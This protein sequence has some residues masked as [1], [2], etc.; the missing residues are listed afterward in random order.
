[1][2]LSDFVG[3][4]IVKEELEQAFL[5]DM[6]PH[7]L[8]IEGEKGTGKRTLAEIIAQYCVCRSEGQKPC[9]F[10][11]GC[12]KALSHSHPDIMVLDGSTPSN[13]NVEAIR[14]LRTSAFIIPNEAPRKVYI[15]A[16][17]D[18][19]N[20]TAQNA[21]LKILEEPPKSV[22]FIL[23][24]ITASSL[25]LTVRSRSRILSLLTPDLQ[26]AENAVLKS[27]PALNPND[28][29][30]AAHLTDGNIGR[31]L[32][33]LNSGG[34]EALR[35]AEQIAVAITETREYNLLVLTSKL[36]GDKALTLAVLD[37]LYE[38]FCAAAKTAVGIEPRSKTTALLA[39][40]LTRSRL[41]KLIDTVTDTK[42]KLQQNAN[43]NLLTTE[44]C[45]ALRRN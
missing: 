19:M 18:R 32:E 36:S 44:L 41:L 4:K 33:L 11:S 3:N 26:E 30:Q 21:F 13:L 35:L 16:N 14:N 10:C 1:M 2:K 29:R 20:P 7:A 31:M 28:V 45:I 8:I 22:V 12:Q 43:M 37:G 38:I 39:Q 23:T 25:L 6:L 24:C 17:C 34:T 42:R 5:S 40:K 27:N 9:G 15:L